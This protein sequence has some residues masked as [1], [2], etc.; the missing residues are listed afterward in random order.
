MIRSYICQECGKQSNT[1]ERGSIPE[2]CPQCR[3]KARKE[4]YGERYVGR[5]YIPHPRPVAGRHLFRKKRLELLNKAQ[6]QCSKCG[7]QS[8]DLD[9]HHLDRNGYGKTGYPDNSDKNLVVLCPSCHQKLHSNS[10]VDI[11][12][13]NH[14]RAEGKTFEQIGQR[15]GVS[16][17]R[18]HQ[19]YLKDIL[20]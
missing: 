5:Y 1:A 9:I 15:F 8:S 11:D 19:L 14:L 20:S 17:Q 2:F 7:G 3:T 10:R 6:N 12:E 4:R 18:I 13:L 16:R